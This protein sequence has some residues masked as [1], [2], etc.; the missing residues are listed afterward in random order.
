MH[1]FVFQY[2]LQ[3]LVVNINAVCLPTAWRANEIAVDSSFKEAHYAASFDFLITKELKQN[4]SVW[5]QDYY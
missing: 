1:I 5:K 2:L 3:R 4:P